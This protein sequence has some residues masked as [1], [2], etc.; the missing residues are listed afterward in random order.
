MQREHS[1]ESAQGIANE[2]I[3]DEEAFVQL[4]EIFLNEDYRLVQRAAWPLGMVGERKPQLLYPYFPQ[5]LLS[6]EKPKHN[7]VSRNIYRSL[8]HMEIPEEHRAPLLD[9]CLRDLKDP[10][11]A[12][13]IKAFAMTV[14]CNIAHDHPEIM[15]ELKMIIRAN[16]PTASK[17]YVARARNL[18]L[19]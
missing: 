14:A 19:I 17:A 3:Q 11:T 7:A 8:Q 2:I 6:L 10:N 4:M 13:A 18:K 15:P 1:K 5:L 16:L 9:L 12:V